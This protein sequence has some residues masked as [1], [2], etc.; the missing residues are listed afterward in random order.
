MPWRVAAAATSASIRRIL[1]GGGTGLDSPV[2]G[3]RVESCD[4]CV[5]ALDLKDKTEVRTAVEPSRASRV[6]GSKITQNQTKLQLAYPKGNCAA[7]RGVAEESGPAVARRMPKLSLALV[8]LRVALVGT[9]R[10][11]TRRFLSQRSRSDA[12]A[13]CL[14]VWREGLARMRRSSQEPLPNHWSSRR[15]SGD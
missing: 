10:V 6:L 12:E 2:G 3:G 9:A 7:L 14:G 11:P 1:R 4:E 5:M 13:S 15:L 8:A